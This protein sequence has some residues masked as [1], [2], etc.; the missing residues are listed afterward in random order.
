[1]SDSNFSAIRARLKY[2]SIEA[3]KEGYGRY[4]SAGGM[5][6]PMSPQK[7]KPVGTTVRFQFLLADG[8]SALL[9]EGVVRQLRGVERDGESGPVG[10]LVKFTKLSPE[11]K[12][13][14]DEVV[15]SKSEH[16]GVHVP[17]EVPSEPQDEHTAEAEI[18]DDLYEAASGRDDTD[19]GSSASGDEIFASASES[20]IE[21]GAVVDDPAAV[22][23]AALAQGSEPESLAEAS[24]PSPEMDVLDDLF[25]PAAPAADE[26]AE[27]PFAPADPSVD[28]LFAPAEQ[29]ADDDFFAPVSEA[30]DGDAFAAQEVEAPAE[31]PVPAPAARALA[32]DRALKHTEGGLKVMAFDGTDHLEEAA[33]EFEAF[34]SAGDDDDIDELFD[35]VFGGGGDDFFGGGGDDLFGGG[36][37]EAA[38][39]GSAPDELE[40]SPMPV[41]PEPPSLP[42]AETPV[43]DLSD[44]LDVVEDDADEEVLELSE[45]VSTPAE[46]SDSVELLLDEVADLDEDSDAVELAEDSDSLELE[47]EEPSDAVELA[48]DSDSL[49]LELEEPSGAVELAEDS[50]S[51][52]L[53]F[54]EEPS[55]EAPSEELLSLLAMDESSEPDELNL[56]LG[57][58]LSESSVSDSDDLSAPDSFEALLANARR[59]IEGKKEPE[60]EK[61]GDILDELLGDDDLPPAPGAAPTFAVPQPGEKKKKGGF[62]SKLFGKD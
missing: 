8:T 27:D 5:F 55:E 49:E 22:V 21:T 46:A 19:E 43:V 25:A 1:M 2:P 54:G 59:E 47:L 12:A 42:L 56:S 62:M 39:V 44:E 35:N 20:A 53:K 61:K 6:V 4:I 34:A 24:E 29:G 37:N 15:R 30:E 38:S 10:M 3:F 16:S 40:E 26:A 57:V 23:A 58:G 7:L 60:D 50:D 52:E 14:I 18:P 28:E 51:L 32:G 17:A 31:S 45:P 41:A 11:S 13:L 33:R 36:G 9:G 48:E